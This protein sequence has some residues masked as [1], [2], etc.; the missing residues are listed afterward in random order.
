MSGFAGVVRDRGA[1]NGRDVHAAMAGAL[2]G[3]GPDASGSWTSDSAVLLHALFRT[4]DES[5]REQQPVAA[6]ERFHLIGDVRL[7]A[8]ADL[9]S[10]L[11]GDGR[12]VSPELPDIELVMHAWVVWRDDCLRH[13]RGDFSFVVW[14]ERDRRLFGARDHFGV[15][16]FYFAALADRLVFGNMLAAI[17]RH[18]D[19]ADD[20]DDEAMVDRLVFGQFE[21][22]ASTAFAAIRRLPGGHTLIWQAGCTEVRRYWPGVTERPIRF[23]RPVDYVD[24]YHELLTR[25]VSDRLRTARVAVAMTGGLD[26]SSIAAIAA[27]HYDT[28]GIPKAVHA[29]TI[30][31]DRL[32]P[33]R[34]RH[35]AG[36]V[37][38]HIHVPIEF[39]TADDH[40]LY[41]RLDDPSLHG[42][43]PEDDPFRAMLTAFYRG[44]SA[45]DRVLLMGLD[46][47]TF[48]CEIASDYLLARLRRGEL[49]EYLRGAASY[50]RTRHSL[51]PHRLRSTLRRILGRGRR[52][53]G[54]DVPAWVEPDM[55]R[56]Y[57][58]AARQ[59][60]RAASMNRL[61]AG[62]PLRARASSVLASPIWASMFD[63]HDAEHLGAPL[64]VRFPFADVELAEF[65]MNIPAVPWCIDKYIARRAL[66]GQLPPDVVVRP[67]APLA[68]DPVRARRAAG[69]RL[70]W[71]KGFRLHPRLPRYVN[72]GVLQAMCA[73]SPD[74]LAVFVDSRPL[75]LN[76]WLWYHFPR[77]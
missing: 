59:A 42:P 21:N 14:D 61:V 32:M 67:K 12:A 25:S 70:P 63:Q 77:S 35:F 51:P 55:I 10:A 75:M 48:L 37:A 57:D 5:S 69:D 4:T 20:L 8:R 29:H 44:I 71:A 72:A 7:D 56:R 66:R 58:L 6:G 39:F 47:D 46:G 50:V 54:T 60:A 33:D 49:R 26:S 1:P 30:V 40:A 9:I 27:R 3:R 18:P 22:P 65:L 64:E 13:L 28:R 73:R 11:A 16:P 38:Q 62:W 31:Y 23:R 74:A 24:R 2:A 68:G 53:L 15:R 17:R 76:E 19:V 41:A 36:L 34:E 45:R 43:E 52:S